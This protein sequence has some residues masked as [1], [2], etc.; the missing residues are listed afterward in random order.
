MD[1]LLQDLHYGF[2]TL[3]RNRGFAA[4]AV[5]T[6]ALGI[7]ANSAIFSI[8]DAVLVRPLP[9]PNA[10]R[11]VKL[12]EAHPHFGKT[13]FLV[14][15]FVEVL[16]NNQNLEQVAAYK[17]DDF[18]LT[19]WEQ[20][21]QVIAKFISQNFFSLLG[22]TPKLGR[23]FL[24]QEYKPGQDR[25]VMISHRLWGRSFGADPNLIGQSVTLDDKS[26]TVV[27]ILPQQFRL[28]PLVDVWVP[29]TLSAAALSDRGDF[30]LDVIGRLNPGV[31]IEQAQ[32]ELSA[33]T[34]RLGPPRF[35][36]EGFTVRLEPL[37]DVLIKDARLKLLLLWGVVGFV[38][39]ISCA[40]VANLMLART[41]GRQKEFAIRTA[42]GR[43]PIQS[44]QAVGY[45]SRAACLHWRRS[46]PA[47]CNVGSRATDSCDSRQSASVQ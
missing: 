5:F 16:N 19:G 12:S 22:V 21:E 10:D 3:L 38:L 9:Y 33:I 25:V 29:L 8:I 27:G 30:A 42:L 43:G 44:H 24:D 31:T 26:Y 28:S 6:L 37:R 46:R 47:H 15:D 1:T 14:P 45:R 23:T 17:S 39:L 18:H 32:S 34:L 11:L 7:G 35:M 4:V 41:A 13:G 36:K 20:P 2:R 40:N